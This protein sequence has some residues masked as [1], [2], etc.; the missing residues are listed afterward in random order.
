MLEQEAQTFSENRVM[1]MSFFKAS[2]MIAIA[3]VLLCHSYL[4]AA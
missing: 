4:M 2:V 1:R 3:L